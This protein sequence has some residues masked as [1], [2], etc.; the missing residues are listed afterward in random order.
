M[1]N[2]RDLATDR[3]TL[4]NDLS[5]HRLKDERVKV[6]HADGTTLA[7]FLREDWNIIADFFIEIVHPKALL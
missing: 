3:L 4:I 1:T 7:V 5:L 6:V 2:E